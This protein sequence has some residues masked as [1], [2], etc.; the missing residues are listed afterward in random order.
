VNWKTETAMNNLN[1]VQEIW[2]QLKKE[3]NLP[4][5]S[6]PSSDLI[7]RPTEIKGTMFQR[8]KVNV[9]KKRNPVHRKP[10]ARTFQIK[11][12][13]PY[14]ASFRHASKDTAKRVNYITA[15][16]PDCVTYVTPLTPTGT[17]LENA[18]KEIYSRY[19]SNSGLEKFTGKKGV[20]KYRFFNVPPLVGY[21]HEGFKSIE[22][23]MSCLRYLSYKH[24]VNNKPVCKVKET[25]KDT[26]T[27]ND[28]EPIVADEC[29][30]PGW[31]D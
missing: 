8:T 23:A 24:S 25:L 28:D 9:S 2:N 12:T 27:Y 1:K 26:T 13:N 6:V 5:T 31:M 30:V 18:N 10:V 16:E 7:T 17:E 14:C 22:K 29:S 3:K 21:P 15:P 4:Y 20:T 19:G 11:K